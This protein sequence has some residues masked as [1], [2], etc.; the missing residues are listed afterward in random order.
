VCLLSPSLAFT[1]KGGEER[2]TDKE[3]GKGEEKMERWKKRWVFGELRPNQ[4]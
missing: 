1:V 3:W 2:P 4:L